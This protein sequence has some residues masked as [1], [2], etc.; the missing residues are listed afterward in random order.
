MT[1]ANIQKISYQNLEFPESLKLIP[2]PPKQLYVCGNL[3][4]LLTMPTV[5]VVGSRSVTTYG[6]QVTDRLVSELVARGIAIISG[7][8]LGVDGRAHEAALNAGGYTV[9]V[10][11][12]GLDRFYPRSHTHIAKRILD[13]GGA[14]ISE[15]PTGTEPYKTNFIAR[16][17]LVSG[18]SD[19]LLIIEA[20]ERSGTLHT[21]NFALDQ[22]KT[23]LA[24][25]GNITSQ[26][27]M[28][29]NN[30]IKSGATPVTS[31]Q[32]ILHALGINEQIRFNLPVASNAEEAII[33]KLLG[34]GTTDSSQ[35][36][37]NS[38]LTPE[39]FNQSLTMLEISGKV[40]PLGA[41]HWSIT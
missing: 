5:S 33:L 34:S 7:L 40:R 14:I 10:M 31:T 13:S 29:T 1:S 27:S 38:K 12:C 3:A 28:G 9:A 24:V 21:A 22:G 4:P 39:I 11:P 30:L 25:P 8:A 6:K 36:L 35:L 20:S 32:D 17:R 2:S 41:G 37:L 19:A 26:N 16:N 23:V 18:L 15:Y